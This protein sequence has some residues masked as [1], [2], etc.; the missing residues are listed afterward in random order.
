MSR[1]EAQLLAKKKGMEDSSK[2]LVFGAS[3]EIEWIVPALVGGFT[4]TELEDKSEIERMQERRN[5]LGEGK[6]YKVSSKE[7]PPSDPQ[8]QDAND[9]MKRMRFGKTVEI[10]LKEEIPVVRSKVSV[11]GAVGVGNSSS[12]NMFLGMGFQRKSSEICKYFNSRGGCQR[13][14]SCKFL[15]VLKK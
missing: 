5:R 9:K 13:G 7:K 4:P 8:Q 3:T 2:S 1:A 15:H 14:S 10:P 6:K 11:Y 12:G